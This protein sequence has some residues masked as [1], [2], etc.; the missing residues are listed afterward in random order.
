MQLIQ[1]TNHALKEWNVAIDALEQGRMISLLRKG[2]IR[3]VG[4]KFAVT[5]DQVL[6]YPTYEHQKSHLL[7]AEYA[8]QVEPVE[9]GWHP[10]TVRIGSWAAIT[11]TLEV[12]D[13][14]HVT[15]LLPFHIWNQEF[16]V[17]RLK[18]KPNQS[19]FVLL[20]RVY[21]LKSPKIIPFKPEYGGCRS[22]IDLDELIGLDDSFPALND[23][24][25]YQRVSEILN[26]VGQIEENLCK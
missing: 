8:E 14:K 24:D 2:G 7:K 3:E 9:S 11:N 17:E 22:W 5:H 21:R 23:Q 26:A 1:Q 19:L 12:N 4:G 20:L 15:S 16:V 18:W 13:P 6:L 10:L 25:Y